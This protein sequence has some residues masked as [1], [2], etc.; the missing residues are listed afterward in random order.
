MAPNSCIILTRHA[1]AKHNVHL[2][3]SN[4]WIPRRTAHPSYQRIRRAPAVERLGGLGKVICL[5]EAQECNDYPCDTG[6]LR[7]TLEADPEFADFNFEPLTPERTSKE[8]FWAPD[9]A[10]LANRAKWVRQ[11]LRDRPEKN[12]V[13]VAHGGIMRRITASPAGP[14]THLWWNAE[15]RIYEFDPMSVKTKDCWLHQ[16]ESVAVAGGYGSTGAEIDIER[17]NRT[18]SVCIIN[19]HQ[20]AYYTPDSLGKLSMNRV[21]AR[22][23][24]LIVPSPPDDSC[25][26][27]CDLLELYAWEQRDGLLLVA[28][29]RSSTYHSSD[30]KKVKNKPRNWTLD[31]NMRLRKT[32]TQLYKCADILKGN[33]TTD[34]QHN[35]GPEQ[36]L[37]TMVDENGGEPLK[38]NREEFFTKDRESLDITDLL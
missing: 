33:L 36:T 14:S 10:A 30:P 6:S 35:D 2:D 4:S 29:D 13:L 21:R 12:I 7:E 11:F 22:Y 18:V 26:C 38:A 9:E 3:Y 16:K 32:Q 19:D 20:A 15:V 1:Q 31:D 34:E 23:P 17:T 25:H 24:Q 28:T 5:P 37:P 27:D 8:G